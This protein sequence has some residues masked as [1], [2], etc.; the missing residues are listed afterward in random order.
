[1][2]KSN[3][4]EPTPVDGQE[5]LLKELEK[6]YP[7]ISMDDR[8]ADYYVYI[9]TILQL[10]KPFSL[11]TINEPLCPSLKEEVLLNLCNN[12]YAEYFHPYRALDIIQRPKSD[13]KV[14]SFISDN[15]IY[16]DELV[17][18]MLSEA[19]ENLVFLVDFS[20]EESWKKTMDKHPSIT[21]FGCRYYKPVLKVPRI[22]LPAHHL[23]H[24]R[25]WLSQIQRTEPLS[26][27]S[28]QEISM[29]IKRTSEKLHPKI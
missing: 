12:N 13:G 2:L 23:N 6:R 18:V 16:F 22:D 4:E 20:S 24:L 19:C 21:H 10:S 14:V 7:A 5:T 1:M 11:F 29:L 9:V 8:H 26:V 28:Q 27:Y 25:F 17:D 15:D 3:Q